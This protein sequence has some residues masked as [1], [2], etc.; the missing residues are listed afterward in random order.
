LSELLGAEA[1][2]LFIDVLALRRGARLS[3][4]L[5]VLMTG[6]QTGTDNLQIFA[7][8]RLRFPFPSTREIGAQI[9]DLA[10]KS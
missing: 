9:I 1:Y 3:W 7:C 4:Q 6:Q 8:G 2:G 5:W 10:D